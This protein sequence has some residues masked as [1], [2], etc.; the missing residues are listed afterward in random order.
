[1]ILL[2]NHKVLFQR[3]EKIFEFFCL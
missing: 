2:S 3:E 1:L